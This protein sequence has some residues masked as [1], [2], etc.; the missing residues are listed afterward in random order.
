[1]GVTVSNSVQLRLC[2]SL[3]IAHC[4]AS[5]SQENEP[6]EPPKEDILQI[7]ESGFSTQKPS[8]SCLS[9]CVVGV[10]AVVPGPGAPVVDV[11]VVVTLVPS[12]DVVVVI[13]PGVPP[14]GGVV[15][16][17]VVVV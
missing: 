9:V 1:M 2:C 7:G 16:V 6:H 12:V 14:P 3:A 11:V 4:M 13:V 17:V 5:P 8:L 15:L 10:G